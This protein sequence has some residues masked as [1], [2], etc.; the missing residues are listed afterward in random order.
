[1]S[2]CPPGISLTDP[3]LCTTLNDAR[4]ATLD[5]PVATVPPL[6]DDTF[7][8]TPLK[9][10]M[11]GCGDSCKLIGYDFDTD[12]ATSKSSVKYVVDTYQT[13]IDNI[14]VLVKKS[15]NV[16]G[17]VTGI[18][19][20]RVSC[21]GTVHYTPATTTYTFQSS[22]DI[23]KK[24]TELQN[25][26]VY[27]DSSEPTVGSLDVNGLVDVPPVLVS[28]PGFQVPDFQA[29]VI[30][31]SN[32]IERPTVTNVDECAAKCDLQAGTCDGFNFTPGLDASPVCE[33]VRNARTGDRTFDP[34]NKL[35][36]IRENI[37]TAQVGTGANPSGTDLGNEGMYCEDA[38]ACNKDIEKL[39][40]DPSGVASFSTED[41]RSCSF[42]PLRT[43]ARTNNVTRNEVGTVTAH[44]TA[45]DALRDLRYQTDG[46]FPTHITIT[47]GKAYRI[48]SFLTGATVKNIFLLADGQI[49]G[50]DRVQLHSDDYG[51]PYVP[52]FGRIRSNFINVYNQD[53][54]PYPNGQGMW[55][56]RDGNVSRFAYDSPDISYDRTYYGTDGK[57]SNMP[58]TLFMFN[59]VDKVIN[60]YRIKCMTT[61][62]YVR[63]MN[64]VWDSVSVTTDLNCIMV[65]EET[66]VQ[67]FINSTNTLLG[68][69]STFNLNINDGSNFYKIETNTA[70]KYDPQIFNWT[71]EADPTNEMYYRT[72]LIKNVCVKHY[73]DDSNQACMTGAEINQNPRKGVTISR[74]SFSSFWDSLATG[75][76]ISDPYAALGQFRT[77]IYSA[78]HTNVSSFNP[79]S[80]GDYSWNCIDN[81]G[82]CIEGG[83]QGWAKY[84]CNSRTVSTST[85]DGAKSPNVSDP[86][87]CDGTRVFC[88]P[89]VGAP[90]LATYFAAIIPGLRVVR[91]TVLSAGRNEHELRDLNFDTIYEKDPAFSGGVI[92]FVTD[93]AI[94]P[95]VVVDRLRTASCTSDKPYYIGNGQC[96]ATCPTPPV[97]DAMSILNYSCRAQQCPE[98]QRPDATKTN[99]VPCADQQVCVTCPSDKVRYSTTYSKCL[100][101]P[102]TYRAADTVECTPCGLTPAYNQT[103]QQ[104]Y[105]NPGEYVCSLNGCYSGVPNSDHTVCIPNC[106]PGYGPN[107]SGTSCDPC[108]LTPSP[109]SIWQSD[110]N[111]GGRTYKCTTESCPANNKAFGQYTGCAPCGPDASTIWTV[112]YVTFPATAL[113]SSYIAPGC[114]FSVCAPG[115]TNYNSSTKRCVSCGSVPVGTSPIY[116]AGTCTITSCSITDTVKINTI[117]STCQILTCKPGYTLC[118]GACIATPTCTPGNYFDTTGTCTCVACS[119]PPGITQTYSASASQT[120]IGSRCAPETCAINTADAQSSV[121]QSV[122]LVS[123]NCEITCKNG[124]SLG[125]YK[126]C[127]QCPAYTNISGTYGRDI[128]YTRNECTM[129]S[130]AATAAVSSMA[131]ASVVGGT[132]VLQNKPGYYIG[133]NANYTQATSVNVCPA[134]DSGTSYTY[135]AISAPTN[136]MWVA[137]VTIYSG[138]CNLATCTYTNAADKNETAAGVLTNEGLYVCKKVCKSGKMRGANGKCS[139]VCPVN[140]DTDLTI[141]YGPYGCKIS[142]CTTASPVGYGAITP[143]INGIDTCALTCPGGYIVTGSSDPIR[144]YCSSCGDINI[145]KGSFGYG[146]CTLAASGGTCAPIH[147]GVIATMNA[148]R[149]CSASCKAGFVKDTYGVCRKCPG[150]SPSSTSAVVN[151]VCVTT[152]KANHSRDVAQDVSG[153]LLQIVPQCLT[154][155]APYVLD[156]SHNICISPTASTTATTEIYNSGGWKLRCKSNYYFS[157]TT[158]LC[159]QCTRPNTGGTD[160]PGTLLVG[161]DDNEGACMNST[162][163]IATSSTVASVGYDNVNLRCVISSC[164]TGYVK[165]AAGA[166]AD[167]NYGYSKSGSTCN[168]CAVTLAATAYWS[169]IGSCTTANCTGR[170]Q[171]NGSKSGCD[172]CSLT[173]SEYWTAASGCAKGT[174]P[175]RSSAATDGLSCTACTLV[176]TNDSV[177]DD[178]MGCAQHKCSTSA[179]ASAN[180]RP[181]PS[182]SSEVGR[183]ASS[184]DFGDCLTKFTLIGTSKWASTDVRNVTQL[185][186]AGTGGNINSIP[187]NALCLEACV[188]GSTWQDGTGRMCQSCTQPLATQYVVSPC[189]PSSD[190]VIGTKLTSSSCVTGMTYFIPAITGTTLVAGSPGSCVACKVPRKYSVGLLRPEYVTA[191]CN[192]TT[193]TT[194]GSAAVT[195]STGGLTGYVPGTP[196]QLGTKPTCTTCT[197]YRLCAAC[198]SGAASCKNASGTCVTCSIAWLM[199]STKVM[200][201]AGLPLGVAN[202]SQIYGIN[203][204]LQAC[205]NLALTDVYANA[206][207][208]E[209]ANGAIGNCYLFYD[210]SP[211]KRYD[212]NSPLLTVTESNATLYVKQPSIQT[213]INSFIR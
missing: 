30:T 40:L 8:P 61:G 19:C 185:C 22:W 17:W 159:T 166:C 128:T 23:D 106:L 56:T 201:T 55:S 71:L 28:P 100:C 91:T 58:V 189:T 69:S 137:G 158:G 115:Y 42:C 45:A 151:G 116:T 72:E 170:S 194:V 102:G 184:A 187:T 27:F 53:V 7:L 147:A 48:K 202:I 182:Y 188:A 150:E 11:A 84:D 43:Y 193:N 210:A 152:C 198:K 109:T 171:P 39:V 148:D 10:A 52:I 161:S 80:R 211:D 209:S 149:T 90:E 181:R 141:T 104:D 172:S 107:S 41:L 79:D 15:S 5:G 6:V 135:A 93:I 62:N 50:Y 117:D 73:S 204:S 167:C 212:R 25:V 66:T 124:Y 3:T 38:P 65:L 208:F 83:R 54:I 99:C 63:Y 86:V 32:L 197:T 179:E 96:A 125:I 18:T 108:G 162:T 118:G 24:P 101:N 190:T 98:G 112:A 213:P 75:A 121:I 192:Q 64:E 103:W 35:G 49:L 44:A 205:Q 120:S 133:Y 160:E 146:T 47:P 186:Q 113:F 74:S 89:P 97:L 82:R 110:F 114:T 164:A 207:Q 51:E 163:C 180:A 132:C 195:C 16:T 168:A 131:T 37:P 156:I 145:L 12:Q 46:S 200:K 105:S 111:Q 130:C 138:Q 4:S 175:G 33:L 81:A 174:C 165:N 154:C 122:S 140:S 88:V 176:D 136:T 183:T 95:S 31:G 92:P 26:Y 34:D 157:L 57:N 60:G 9:N 206:F 68:N 85:C 139:A 127:Y 196:S 13:T 76:D 20:S 203:I 119:A 36:F 177:W 143:V 77:I 178:T 21:T 59:I 78:S 14:A 169:A 70:R 153:N 87:S 1:M 155:I 2:S 129:T 67:E 142:T 144:N 134:G 173:G 94:F 199:A 126:M 123:G 191:V 29:S